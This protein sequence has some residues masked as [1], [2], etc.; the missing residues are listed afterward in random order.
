[1]NGNNTELWETM[2]GNNGRLC[3]KSYKELHSGVESETQL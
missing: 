2:K 1:M 3:R